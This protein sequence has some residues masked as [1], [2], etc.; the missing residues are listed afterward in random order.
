MG[1][2]K[3]PTCAPQEWESQRA[4]EQCCVV[5]AVTG[6]WV[7]FFTFVFRSIS[8]S[9]LLFFFIFFLKFLI[10]FS[11]EILQDQILSASTDDHLSASVT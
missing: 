2:C 3:T 10:S 11:Y 5:S 1:R 9:Y 4:A 7:L 8:F 6:C